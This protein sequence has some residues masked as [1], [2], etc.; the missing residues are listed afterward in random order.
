MKKFFTK[1]T[2]P[3]LAWALAAPAA[4]AQ[5]IDPINPETDFR[6]E[7]LADR[8]E[9]VAVWLLTIIGIV[10]VIFI[11]Y[12]AFLYIT[13]AGKEEQL[14]KAKSVIIYGLFGILIAVLSF[15]IISFGAS[16]VQ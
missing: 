16:F 1:T 4:L 5:N 15:A 14:G 10:A 12:G 6:K 2:A 8:L 9:E 11:L 3:V 7:D 13:A